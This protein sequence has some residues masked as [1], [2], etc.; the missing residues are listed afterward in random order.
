MV[1]DTIFKNRTSANPRIPALPLHRWGALA[2]FLLPV[3]FVLSRLI[4]LM[5]NLRDATGR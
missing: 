2:C 4:Y 1:Q 3:A 5:G